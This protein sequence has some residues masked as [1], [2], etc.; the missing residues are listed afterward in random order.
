MLAADLVQDA[1]AN[2]Q[3]RVSQSKITPEQGLGGDGGQT[4]HMIA[5]IYVYQYEVV[6]K[7][8]NLWSKPNFQDPPR[9]LRSSPPKPWG[10][11]IY[12]FLHQNNNKGITTATQ[13]P[14]F[15]QQP[16]GPHGPNRPTTRCNFGNRRTL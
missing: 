9:P 1:A 11:Q 14:T 7:C 12:I 4:L 8:T 10:L 13:T 3:D 6:H 15:T 16:N 5:I 2:F